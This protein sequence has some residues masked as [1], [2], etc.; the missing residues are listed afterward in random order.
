MFGDRFGIDRPT[1]AFP[2]GDANAELIDAARQLDVACGLTTRHQLVRPSD[3]IYSWG[4]F[5]AGATDTP[6]VLAA[7]LSGWYT[8]VATAG[9]TVDAADRDEFGR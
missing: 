6:V 4:R 2:Y 7:K 1:F 5:Y 3:D 8:S 9:K